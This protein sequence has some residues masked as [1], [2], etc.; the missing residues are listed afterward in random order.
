MYS[1]DFS[2]CFVERVF[3]TTRGGAMVKRS[4]TE[5]VQN[6]RS[7]TRRGEITEL[8]ESSR[9]RL[10]FVASNADCG[11]RSMITL[12]YGLNFPQCGLLVKADLKVFLNRVRALCKGVKYL[13]FLEFQRR[14]APH[15]HI[16]L[17]EEYNERV[18]C[19]LVETWIEISA[20]Y[21]PMEA[22]TSEK[23]KITL[24]NMHSSPRGRDFWQNAESPGGLSHYA[25]KYA[26]KTRQKRVPQEYADV[27][28]FWGASRDLVIF[29]DS[30]FIGKNGFPTQKLEKIVVEK[31]LRGLPKYIFGD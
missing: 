11:W 18:F 27:G 7:V 24:F 14:G 2:Q 3:Y 30:E 29:S 6:T 1:I 9:K 22:Y 20:K 16:L 23:A 31:G 4:T 15:V 10:A 25:V 8:S 28:R 21:A 26:T 17:S 19:K 12:T 13:W 5:E